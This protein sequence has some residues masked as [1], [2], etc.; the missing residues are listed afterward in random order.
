MFLY[1]R[2]FL[3]NLKNGW[4]TI[5][6]SHRSHSDVQRNFSEADPHS[7]V[8]GRQPVAWLWTT[9]MLQMAAISVLLIDRVIMTV[10]SSSPGPS[11]PNCTLYHPPPQKKIK[12]TIQHWCSS[13]LT[14]ANSEAMLLTCFVHHSAKR[15]GT[16]P[17][18]LTHN[19]PS[20]YSRTVKPSPALPLLGFITANYASAVGPL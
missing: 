16:M 8:S 11:R 7:P 12:M 15:A 5:F 9:R 13:A 3:I 2:Q 17:K 20:V 18:Q 14:A 6:S 4:G 10:T 1:Q 19:S